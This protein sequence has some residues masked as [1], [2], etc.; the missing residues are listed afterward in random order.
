MVKTTQV[1]FRLTDDMVEGIDRHV[2]RLRAANPQGIFNR[3]DAARDLL[4]RA[5]AEVE[6]ADDKGPAKGKR[7]RT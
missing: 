2:E 5:L 6:A 3:S 4:A 7:G 1:A